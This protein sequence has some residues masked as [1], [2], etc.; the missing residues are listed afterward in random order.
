MSSHRRR[1]GATP[2]SS[3]TGTAIVLLAAWGLMSCGA[4]C[5]PSGHKWKFHLF[6][7]TCQWRPAV[8][9]AAAAAATAL[10]LGGAKYEPREDPPACS[11]TAA[12]TPS[13]HT[14]S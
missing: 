1:A 14:K 13:S 8:A 11:A 2:E 6:G 9:E 5:D 3:E 10:G 12:G 7:T 4:L